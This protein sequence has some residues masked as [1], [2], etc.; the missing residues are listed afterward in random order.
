MNP[1]ST[2]TIR[3]KVL[4]FRRPL[5]TRILAQLR[6]H[7]FTGAGHV[8]ATLNVSRDEA[9]AA[10]RALVKSGHL[11]PECADE[12]WPV[13]IYRAARRANEAEV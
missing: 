4:P 10:L 11:V 5:T 6:E 9:R 2:E 12:E 13:Y 3:C 7:P 8:A 1:H